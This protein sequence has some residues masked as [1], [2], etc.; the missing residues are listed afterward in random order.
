MSRD[1]DD[2]AGARRPSGSAEPPTQGSGRRSSGLD[3][4]LRAGPGWSRRAPALA[5]RDRAFAGGGSERRGTR[6]SAVES[7]CVRRSRGSNGRT[8]RTV[9][10]VLGLCIGPPTPSR[11]RRPCPPTS[12]ARS[13]RRAIGP[14]P[15]R[16]PPSPALYSPLVE[17]RSSFGCLVEVVETLVLTLIIF[18]V[19]QTFIAQPYQ[20]QQNSMERTLEPGQYVLVDKLTPRWDAYGRGDIVV[21]NPPASWTTETTPFIKRV[22]GL[23]G[24]TVEVN[25]DGLVYVNGTPLDE[26]YTYTNERGRPRAD[27]VAGPGAL[28]RPRRA[29]VRD[30]RPPPEVRRLA[31]VRADRRLGRR[32]PC[33]P[34]LLADLDL[35]DPP[36]AVLPG[37][38][39]G[40][41]LTGPAEPI[42]VTPAARA[43]R[44]GRRRGRGR[45]RLRPRAALRDAR[46]VRGDRRRGLRRRSAPRAGRARRT[47]RRGRARRLPH[48]GRPA[49]SA[50]Q[51]V[52]LAR[53]LAGCDGSGGRRVR[54]GLARRGH[55]R[56]GPRG[57]GGRGAVGG[58]RRAG[59]RDRVARVACRSGGRVRA[60]RPLGGTG[61]RR[62][63]RRF[64][65]ASA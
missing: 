39:V 26:S 22:I 50:R 36:D 28:G 20:V 32:R 51:D 48:L 17:R 16:R 38:P 23:P 1:R 43:P 18:F 24:D 37:R 5:R 6:A 35:R 29:A 11:V 47:A 54:G 14:R 25:D 30:G 45:G 49:P 55:G 53:R 64:A 56:R 21:F 52:R 13:R 2:P 59:A 63:R 41:T 27:E 57:D 44:R 60:A 61:A 3:P 40:V 46:R 34:P 31:R 9:T 15:E 65:W 12:R 42:V 19:I 10:A 62:A 8:G 4:R 7:V 33:L 58:R